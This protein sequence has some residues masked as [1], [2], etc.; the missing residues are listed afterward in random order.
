MASLTLDYDCDREFAS[1]ELG[2]NAIT[3]LDRCFSV[4]DGAKPN[5]Y[6]RTTV[7]D[8]TA[9]LRD[10]HVSELP[11]AHHPGNHDTHDLYLRSMV[12]LPCS[13]RARLSCQPWTQHVL[14][15]CH[16]KHTYVWQCCECG[17]PTSR[18][19]LQRERGVCPKCSSERSVCRNCSSC[20]RVI[21]VLVR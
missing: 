12:L 3:R 18:S 13:S 10:A 14:Y 2:Y 1:H 15:R 5:A 19:R 4:R 16:K 17:T 8:D 6:S 20:K 11:V 9:L 7:C 21:N